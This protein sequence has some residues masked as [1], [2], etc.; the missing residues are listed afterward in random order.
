MSERIT[1][2][3]ENLAVQGKSGFIAYVTAGDP[4]PGA[5]PEILAALD[6]AGT[7]VIELGIPFSDPLA[8]GP[9]I[10]AASGRALAAGMTVRGILDLVREFR[11]SS[12]TPVV[13]FTYLNPIFAFGFEAFIQEAV[14]AGADGLL[15]LD[16]P[17]EEAAANA[18]MLWS[19]GLDPIRLVAPTT[20]AGRMPGICE[21]ARGF[22][23]YVSREGVTGEQTSLST[24]IASQV[25]MLRTFTKLPIAVGFGISTPE[26]SAE[27]ARHADAVVVGSAIVR[28]IAECPDRKELARRVEEFVAPLASAA[29]SARLSLK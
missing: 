17:P 28:H 22:L 3:F 21:T 2:T 14:E 10:Q 6:R 26:Q 4:S 25:E 27:V 18:G 15:V 11:K 9:T 8:D 23:Y 5:M 16:M 29:H 1:K 7:D 12:S 13:L 24:S 19:G 20:P